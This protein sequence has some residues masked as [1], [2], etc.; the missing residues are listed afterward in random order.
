MKFVMDERGKKYILNYE[1]DFQSDLGTI[2]K[3]DIKK[4]NVGDRLITHLNKEFKIIKPN[5]ND[6]I[7]LMNRQCSILI[8]KDIGAVLAHTGIGAGDRIVDAGTGAGAI[9][10]HFG[11]VVGDS[12]MVY[13]YEIREDFAKIAKENIELFGLTNIQIKNKDI[14]DGIDEEN[15]DL[16]F[17]DLIKPYEIIE[18]TYKSLKFGGWIAIYSVYLNGIQI[19]HKILKKTG[20]KDISI[21]ETLNRKYEVKNQGIRPKTR[22]IGHSG[23]LLFAR[24]L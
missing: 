3:E 15:I 14:K 10:L 5:V 4:S 21:I 16:V 18:E 9:L 2:K 17:L 22:M 7:E 19:S 8:Q 24:K 11:N 23:Y 6:F 20:F 13:S 1:N 12:G